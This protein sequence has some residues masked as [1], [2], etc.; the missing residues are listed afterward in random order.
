MLFNGI[1]KELSGLINRMTGPTE[2][3]S[4]LVVI[5]RGEEHDMTILRLY[6][7]NTLLECTTQSEMHLETVTE[8]LSPLDDALIRISEGV[9]HLDINICAEIISPMMSLD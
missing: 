6:V 8:V 2:A 7:T 1:R 4:S 3:D 9:I 5:G